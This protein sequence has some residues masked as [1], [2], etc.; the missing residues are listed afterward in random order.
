MKSRTAIPLVTPRER[1]VLGWIEQGKRNREIAIILGVSPATVKTHV[2]R[3]LWKLD[4]ETRTSAVLS[5]RSAGLL[6]AAA[7]YAGAA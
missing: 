5:A 7:M 6:P 1:E 4:C 3:I 2:E